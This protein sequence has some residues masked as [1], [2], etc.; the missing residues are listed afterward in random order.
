MPT[1]ELVGPDVEAFLGYPAQK[2]WREQAVVST[3]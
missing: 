1:V 3:Q 2:G